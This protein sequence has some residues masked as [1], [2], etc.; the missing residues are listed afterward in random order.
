M[1]LEEIRKKKEEE[2]I[3]Q[4][5]DITIP[6]LLDKLKEVFVGEF[7]DTDSEISALVSLRVRSELTEQ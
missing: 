1:T 5:L 3:I 6:P 7:M 2:D 4:S